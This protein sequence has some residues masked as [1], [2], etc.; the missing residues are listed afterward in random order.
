MTNSLNTYVI[1]SPSNGYC[2]RLFATIDEN[3][4]ERLSRTELKAFILGIRFLELD[5]DK[6]DAVHKLM[7]DFDT[8]NDDHV[9]IEE[10]INGIKKWLNEARR[11][12]DGPSAADSETLQFIDDFHQVSWTNK[13]LTA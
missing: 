11:T 13:T 12:Q 3:Q 6:D 7:Q 2:C 1:F 9:D 4:D 10:F 8:S 5:L